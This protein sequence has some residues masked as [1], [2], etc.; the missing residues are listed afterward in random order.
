LVDVEGEFG[1]DMG[2]C[3]FGIVDAWA[4]PLFELREL[5]GDREVDGGTV[6]DGVA[7]VMRERADSEGQLVGSLRVVKKGENEVAGADIVSEVGEEFVAERVVAE[8]LNGT[9]AV[10]VAVGFLELGFGEGG[11]VF[12]EN[13]ADG[14]LPGEVDEFLMS[15][16]GVRDGRRC[17]EQKCKEGGCFQEG[18]AAGGRNRSSSFLVCYDS[19]HC[20]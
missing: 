10:G 15:L 17:R 5:D 7:D 19:T 4:I 14:L 13:G 1:L 11:V 16:D 12:E 20:I 9:A 18:S 8:V 6:A 3:V 2:M